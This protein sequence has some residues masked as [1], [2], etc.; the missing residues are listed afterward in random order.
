VG[1]SLAQIEATNE[2]TDDDEAPGR[3]PR[4]RS[5]IVPAVHAKQKPCE[6]DGRVHVPPASLPCA[7]ARQAVEQGRQAFDSHLKRV[8]VALASCLRDCGR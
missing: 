2:A 7:V 5:A 6:L 3:L 4:L 1:L 8:R